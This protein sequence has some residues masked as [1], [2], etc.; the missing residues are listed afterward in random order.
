MSKSE[1]SK[2]WPAATQTNNLGAMLG[3]QAIHFWQ[4]QENVLGEIEKFTSRWIDRRHEVARS[5]LKATDQLRQSESGFGA[6]PAILQSWQR[7]SVEC[8]AEDASDW[9][10]L[11]STC[12]DIVTAGEIEAESELIEMAGM[13]NDP[14]KLPTR[15]PV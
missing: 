15:I 5:A 6:A 10:A 13:T 8:M 7:L 1:K 3:P 9:I 14:G 12:A 11:W 4:A 2:K